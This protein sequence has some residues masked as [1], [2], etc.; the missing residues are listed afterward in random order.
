MRERVVGLRGV[1]RAR[2]S[3][4]ATYGDSGVARGAAGYSGHPEDASVG[5]AGPGSG[6]FSFV[7]QHHLARPRPAGPAH[8]RP[9]RSGMPDLPSLGPRSAWEDPLHPTV[10]CSFLPGLVANICGCL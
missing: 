1:V 4:A 7:Y 9:P 6:C 3:G 8:G 2:R 10:P 5:G